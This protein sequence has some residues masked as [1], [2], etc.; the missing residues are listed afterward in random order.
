ARRRLYESKPDGPTVLIAHKFIYGKAID[1]PK[2]MTARAHLLWA[3]RTLDDLPETYVR[4]ALGSGTEERIHALRLA[5]PFLGK[6]PELETLILS[7]GDAPSPFVRFQL[8]LTAGELHPSLAAPLLAY[9]LRRP[10]A[11]RWLVTAAL[12]SAKD[13]ALG[14]L[15][16][17]S[18]DPKFA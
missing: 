10:D 12:S 18:A 2:A 16:D 3:L 8:A 11:D 14:L 4:N 5:E 1:G 17:L 7:L 15:A 9:L 6:Y 13:A